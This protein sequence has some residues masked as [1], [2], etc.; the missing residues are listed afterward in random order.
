MA[1]STVDYPARGTVVLHMLAGGVEKS[2]CKYGNADKASPFRRVVKKK[3]KYRLP[4][5]FKLAYS[6]SSHWKY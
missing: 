1:D 5:L 6:L 2:V 3:I 4:F